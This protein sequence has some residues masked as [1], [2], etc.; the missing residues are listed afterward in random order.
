MN[1]DWTKAP[2]GRPGCLKNK[3]GDHRLRG[4]SLLPLGEVP[5]LQG[6]R[7]K[8]IEGRSDRYARR[9]FRFFGKERT[10]KSGKGKRKR[11]TRLE[12]D[13]RRHVDGP[14]D[15]YEREAK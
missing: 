10:E 12:E 7:A 5:E 14:Y 4:E 6:R 8:G 1:K 3:G 13:Q 9:T 2:A 15:T 11:K